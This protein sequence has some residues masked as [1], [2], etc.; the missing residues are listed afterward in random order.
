MNHPH[1]VEEITRLLQVTVVFHEHRVE[2][3]GG[4]SIRNDE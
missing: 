2:S 4:S 3:S 1:H